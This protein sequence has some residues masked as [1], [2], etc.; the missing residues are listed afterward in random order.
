MIHVKATIKGEPDVPAITKVFDYDDEV[1]FSSA[2]VIEEKIQRN[3][4]INANEALLTYCA[5]VTRSVHAGRKDD[6]IKKEAPKVLSANSVMIG[7]PETLRIIT[8][9][10]AMNKRVAK[11]TLNQPIPTSSYIMAGH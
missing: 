11:I 4:K 6:D 5:Y 7:V 8:F 10:V 1:F 3:M 9:E 2:K